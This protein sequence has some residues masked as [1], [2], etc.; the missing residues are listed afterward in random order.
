MQIFPTLQLT[1]C[2]A[3]CLLSDQKVHYHAP[4]SAFE[5]ISEQQVY[6]MA[7]PC[8]RNIY[9]SLC[10]CPVNQGTCQK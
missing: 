7:S 1:L 8:I 2:R 4:V 10:Y 3:M 5:W 9:H 6:L